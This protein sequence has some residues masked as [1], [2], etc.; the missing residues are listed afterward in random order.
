MRCDGRDGASREGCGG[1][2]AAQRGGD[3]VCGQ[4]RAFDGRARQAVGTAANTSASTILNCGTAVT[5]QLASSLFRETR[6]P[7]F[8]SL[9]MMTWFHTRRPSWS[10]FESSPEP[11]LRLP[12]I[13]LA[14][15]ISAWR[16]HTVAVQVD[17]DLE[18][19]W[20]IAGWA[21]TIVRLRRSPRT[22]A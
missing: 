7:V 6:L 19:R 10:A 18:R 11:R 20:M 13:V 22:G 3:A 8:G 17:G 21:A 1:S 14:L 15:Q 12:R 9:R 4:A 5:C 2:V 16:G